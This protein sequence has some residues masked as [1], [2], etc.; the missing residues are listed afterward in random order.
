MVRPDTPPPTDTDAVIVGQ[1]D[2]GYGV[3]AL[4][5]AIEGTTA[6]PGGGIFHVTWSLAE[7]R[8]SKES[9]DV[10]AGKA[11]SPVDP[12]AISLAGARIR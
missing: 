4:V 9:N 3:E 1:I 5:V 10:L 12:M 7:G 11:W 8:R 2:D 6:R